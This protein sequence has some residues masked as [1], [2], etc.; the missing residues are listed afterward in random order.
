LGE[1]LT[2]REEGGPAL[3]LAGITH[4]ARNLVTAMGL[5]AEL[6]NQPGVLP[7][8]HEHFGAQIRSIAESSGMLVQR[9]SQLCRKTAQNPDRPATETTVTDLSESV[10]K[11]RSLLTAIVGPV[12]DVQLACLPCGGALR[13]SE[14]NLSR[15]LVNLVR[16]A[17]DA[18]PTGGKIRIATQRGGGP[19]FLWMVDDEPGE[20]RAEYLWDDAPHPGGAGN[21]TVVLTVED[22]GPGIP[23]E[24]MERVFERGFSTRHGGHSW[25][26]TE[27]RGLGLS[28]VRQLVEAAG[29]RVCAT[30]APLGGARI[31][32][33]VPLTPVTPTLLSD[34]R[35]NARGDGQ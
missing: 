7:P 34:G 11:M 22:T 10:R 30:T 27:R 33:E 23:T 8:Q 24:F 3:A 9:L 6:I 15:I 2:L 16:N 18:M 1:G 19:G 12:I 29:G 26:E 28:I 5:C 13:L 20:Q 14:E 25:P 21:E 4:D 17:A 35:R 32:I 31:E